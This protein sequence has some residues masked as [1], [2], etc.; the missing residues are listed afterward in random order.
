MKKTIFYLLTLISSTLLVAQS[1][2]KF[3]NEVYFQKNINGA[4]VINTDYSAMDGTPYFTKDFIES[5]VFFTEDSVYKIP[6]RYNIFEQTMEYKSGNTVYAISNPEIFKKIEMGAQTF[7]YY[8][9]RENPK[10]SSYYELLVDGK[11]L[12]LLKRETH[13]REAVPAKAMED[14]KPPRFFSR[15]DEYYIVDANKLPVQIKNK[16]SFAQIYTDK[17]SEIS[18]FIKKEKISAKKEKDLIQLV[19]YYNTL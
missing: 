14:A 10:K 12:L 15:P 16:K 7:V 8:Y 9:N 2:N 5:K 3:I 11:S 1:G 13:Y 6:L 17:K 18:K 4:H 19:K